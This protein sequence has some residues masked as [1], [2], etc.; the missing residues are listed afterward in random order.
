M[1]IDGMTILV[2]GVTGTLGERVAKRFVNEGAEVR[3]LVRKLNNSAKYKS[4]GVTP[5]LGDLTDLD[6]LIHATRS[7]DIIIH[8]AAYLGDDPDEAHA[9][10]ILGVDNLAR[11]ALTSKVIKFIHISTT[12]VYGE[13]NEGFYDETSPLAE[14]SKNTYIR[15]KAQS[16][17]ILNS[18]ASQGLHSIIL[19]PGAI[20]AEENSYWG[21]R[22]IKRMIEADI[23]SW[24]H[25]ADLVAWVHAD[26]LVEMIK[27]VI[28]NGT[29]GEVYNAIDGNFE[30]ND[31]RV[32]LI[33]TLGKPLE[34]PN[35][36]IERPVF[37]NTKIK[38]LGYIPVTSFD[39]T[40]ANLI[41]N[42]VGNL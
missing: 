5:I 18:Y 31:F 15:S 14:H 34:I 12:S 22:Q 32:K 42:A 8:C 27:L 3:V 23:V 1:D 36:S 26:N 38:E 28:E 20:C 11:A 29:N 37:S 10:N 40:M 41:K 2:T 33:T 24:V 39:E 19:R 7:V 6:S 13:S 9:A 17:S 35:R 4:L 30:E 21:D 16:E 25:P